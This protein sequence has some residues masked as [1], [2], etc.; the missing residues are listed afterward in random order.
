MYNSE[1]YGLQLEPRALEPAL[2]LESLTMRFHHPCSMSR[3]F[4]SLQIK[5]TVALEGLLHLMQ[6]MYVPWVHTNNA[7]PDTV[8]KDF[9]GHMH[10]FMAN[11]TESVYDVRL[12]LS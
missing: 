4:H 11:L 2:M 6:D 8:K 1:R 3:I 9:V 12:T 10:K 7:W 5:S